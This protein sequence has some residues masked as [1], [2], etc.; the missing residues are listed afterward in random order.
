MKVTDA[1]VYWEGRT[2]FCDGDKREKS[3]FCPECMQ[4]LNPQTAYTLENTDDPETYREAVVNAEIEI[5][6]ANMG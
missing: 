4:K 1:R 5:L 2:C 3:S 6:K